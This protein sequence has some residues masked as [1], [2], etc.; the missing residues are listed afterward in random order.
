MDKQYLQASTTNVP[1][2]I[3]IVVT[4]SLSFQFNRKNSINMRLPKDSSKVWATLKV[5]YK[6]RLYLFNNFRKNPQLNTLHKIDVEFSSPA[7]ILL[8]L[9]WQYALKNHNTMLE[10]N[11]LSNSK[12]K[13]FGN[14]TGTHK[15]KKT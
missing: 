6:I 12:P 8:S 11:I 5:M 2:V 15:Y 10:Y 3:I 13:T 9:F 4:S 1:K 14:K 7:S